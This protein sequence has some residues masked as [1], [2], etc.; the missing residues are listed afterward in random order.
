MRAGIGVATGEVVVGNVGHEER[1]EYTV[2]GDAVNAAAR[3]TELAKQV[4]GGVL[5]LGESLDAARVAERDH[6]RERDWTTLRGR[7]S[8]TRLVGLRSPGAEGSVPP[9]TSNV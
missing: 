1:F 4:P 2:I 7:S 5:A 3:L 8:A 6:W 9:A